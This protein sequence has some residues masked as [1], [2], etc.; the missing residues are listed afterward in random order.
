MHTLHG[1]YRQEAPAC[2]SGLGPVPSEPPAG[3]SC[4][5]VL[6]LWRWLPPDGVCLPV[7]SLAPHPLAQRS[8][9]K[10]W[11]SASS[12]PSTLQTQVV[13]VAGGKAA[14]DIPEVS[15]TQTIEGLSPVNF[16]FL[17]FKLRGP[18]RFLPQ[19]PSH[20]ANPRWGQ[21]EGAQEDT[22]D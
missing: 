9:G 8:R 3:P 11:D 22:R 16:C 13:P 2:R 19:L 5:G 15:R 20:M 1:S 12:Q 18:R 10:S 14:S 6:P 4:P 7:K 17:P 21:E